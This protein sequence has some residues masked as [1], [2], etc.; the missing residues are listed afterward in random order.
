MN[1]EQKDKGEKGSINDILHQLQEK[2]RQDVERVSFDRCKLVKQAGELYREK[3]LD[4]VSRELSLPVNEAKKLIAIYILLVKQP[5][6]DVTMLATHYGIQFYG[7]QKTWDEILEDSADPGDKVEK[8][9]REFVGATLRTRDINDVD[10]GQELPTEPRYPTLAEQIGKE[11]IN[12]FVKQINYPLRS[13]ERKSQKLAATIK[14]IPP[15]RIM[16]R[17][18]EVATIGERIAQAIGK[19]QEQLIPRLEQLQKH[20]AEVQKAIEEGISNFDDPANYR[21]EEV[22]VNKFAQ[23]IALRWIGIFI[24]IIEDREIS[25]FKPYTNRLKVALEDY[26]TRKPI[27]PIFLFISIQDGL[28]CWLCESDQKIRPN[29]YSNGQPIYRHSTKLQVLKDKYR[30]WFGVRKGHFLRKLHSFY[31]HRNAIM[32]G[33]PIAHF[34][35]NIATISLL[36]LNLTLN[37]AL[38]E[39]GV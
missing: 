3:N 11:A 38:K 35:M 25:E 29:G 15:E 17:V 2:K 32:H 36:F 6:E 28:M 12:K 16:R 9:I 19:L 37:T 5:P 10:L 8:F 30:N 22:K 39:A 23:K 7:A 1:E 20:F 31:A 13:V 18:S 24:Q 34:D 26:N 27:T 14:F 33:D 4:I 21:P